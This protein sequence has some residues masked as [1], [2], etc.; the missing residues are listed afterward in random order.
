LNSQLHRVSRF[1]REGDA[2]ASTIVQ[3]YALGIAYFNDRLPLVWDRNFLLVE[4]GSEPRNAEPLES[5]A[6][7]L[8]GR[9]GLLHRKLVFEEESTG[10]RLAPELR[11][12][13]WEERRLT[14]MVHRGADPVNGEVSEVD[15]ASLEPAV[16]ELLRAEPYGGSQEAVRQLVHADEALARTLGQRCFAK[17]VDGRV[18]SYC[19]LYSHGGVAQVEDVATLPRWRGKG[20]AGAVVSRAVAE[21]APTHGLTFLLAVDGRWVV[22]WYAR[23]GFE[24]VG[25]RYEFTQH[26]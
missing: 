12:S 1:L 14:V 17:L 19:R 21:A 26:R 15:R 25:L 22:Q 24:E 8:Q 18:A 6:E 11:A 16:A 2:G 9:A 20:F 4:S 10:A 13:G 7:L 5:A 23:L 3:R